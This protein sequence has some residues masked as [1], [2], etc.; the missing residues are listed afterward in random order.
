MNQIPLPVDFVNRISSQLPYFAS[1]LINS[2]D[3][4]PSVSVRIHPQKKAAL[5]FL[6]EKVPWCDNGFY[7]H[8]RPVFTLDPLFHAGCYYPQ[9]ASS[10]FLSE[11]LKQ[12]YPHQKPETV[13][14]LC[15]APG[16]K[17]TIIASFLDHYGVLVSN[18]VIKHR[19]NIL[20]ENILKWGYA[21]VVV[22]N[23][24]PA[25]L[26]QLSGLFELIVVDAPC[27]GE[28]MFRKDLQSRS[29]WSEENA[30]M[31]ASRQQQIIDDIWPAL[32][33]GGYLIYSTC[34]FNPAE[35]EEN[36]KWISDEFDCKFVEMPLNEQYG[37]TKVVLGDAIG[38]AFYPGKTKGEGFFI[39]ILKK[40]ITTNSGYKGKNTKLVQPR[41]PA[42]LLKNQN[43]FTTIQLG[44]D[45]V[46][47]PPQLLQLYQAIVDKVK[48]IHAGI[49]LGSMIQNKWNPH[50]GLSMSLFN[51][52]PFEKYEAELIEAQRF[53][54]GETFPMPNM[55][56][57]WVEVCYHSIPL[58]YMKQ[59]GNRANNYY[60]K[61][62]RIRMEIE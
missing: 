35:N 17:S 48:V 29:H 13:L 38:Y 50:H 51:N 16:G 57:G 52:S 43:L 46:A 2:L 11:V 58:G 54:R 62:W 24:E 56:P 21:N 41:V 40:G 37:I 61:E 6:G 12:L 42:G 7:I 34:T 26:G 32:K 4:E 23:S 55:N 36:L 3:S 33:S 30:N 47:M 44:S 59:I 27:S 20:S 5:S 14:D 22:T 53:L 15:A 60:P 45:V 19:A 39:S 10:M 25:R 28:G 31:C 18:E 8:D 1:D 9:E 49:P